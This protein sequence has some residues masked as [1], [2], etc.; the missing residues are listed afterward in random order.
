MRAQAS[1]DAEASDL[2]NSSSPR[3]NKAR[4]YCLHCTQ[5][6]VPPFFFFKIHMLLPSW[7]PP[8]PCSTL[9]LSMRGGCS[10]EARSQLLLIL[11]I[12]QWRDG[13]TK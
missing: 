5:A 2:E 1:L 13:Q 8:P 6:A 9:A 12:I 11:F 7:P 4:Q 3:D 10:D